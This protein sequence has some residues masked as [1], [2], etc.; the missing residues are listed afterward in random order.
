MHAVWLDL[1]DHPQEWV[2]KEPWDG[3]FSA[4][5]DVGEDDERGHL[6]GKPGAFLQ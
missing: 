4:T 1:H 6:V 5:V 2:P 3:D